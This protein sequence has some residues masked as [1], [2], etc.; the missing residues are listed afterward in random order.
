MIIHFIES[1]YFW[2]G[3]LSGQKGGTD[4]DTL[5][6]GDSGKV[7]WRAGLKVGPANREVSPRT[8]C[9]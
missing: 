6:W 5:M 8:P 3:R 4:A 1:G 2:R 9:R 7:V